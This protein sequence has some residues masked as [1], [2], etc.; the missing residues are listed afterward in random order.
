ML[1]DDAALGA[2]PGHGD[3]VETNLAGVR[4][5]EPAEQRYQGGF[6]R[7]GVADDSDE[8][9]DEYADGFIR[10]AAELFEEVRDEL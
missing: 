1:E 8:L 4:L 6:S 7:P 3:A 5:D 10:G 2:G 9:S